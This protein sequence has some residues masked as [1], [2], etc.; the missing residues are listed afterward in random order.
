MTKRRAN[1]EG[2]V[3][4]RKDGRWEGRITI[5]YREDGKPIQ[6]SLYAR[7]QD[8]LLRRL[9]QEIERYRDMVIAED[10]KMTLRD[11]LDRWLHEYIQYIVRENTFRDYEQIIQNHLN[12]YLGDKLM[13]RITK[14][15][16]QKLYIHL[17]ENGH[18]RKNSN[19]SKSLSSGMVRRIHTVLHQALEKAVQE[20]IIVMNPTE[21]VTLPSLNCTPKHILNEEQL[22]RFLEEAKRY[23][24]WYVFFYLEMT[25]GLRR[26]EICGLQWTDLNER[27]GQLHIMRSIS[28]GKGQVCQPKTE[29]GMRTI[30]LS[31]ST[32]ESLIEW[33]SQTNS[34]WIFPNP[35]DSHKPMPPLRAYDQLKIILEDAELPDIRF[36]GLRHTFATHA[37]SG[38]VDA[39][40]LSEILGHT[41]PS[42]TLDTYTHVTTQMHKDASV[43]VENFLGQ[44][45]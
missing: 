14:R 40:T 24:D 26:G 8:E 19:Q 11:W 42:F 10:C 34:E 15:D 23:A 45:M 35:L 7:T 44:I 13:Y 16:I 3:R 37:L 28:R 1:G 20:N 5:G 41:N 30:T 36:H 31:H 39:K 38:G 32:L 25:T 21:G 29:A 33:K 27:T 2:L 22:D 12:P 6:R 17:K 18:R 9:H 4:K 43:I